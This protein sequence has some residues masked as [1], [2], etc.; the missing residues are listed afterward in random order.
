MENLK[1]RAA[2]KS[3]IGRRPENEDACLALTADDIDGIEGLLIVA[4]GMGG[5]ASGAVASGTAVK[6]VRDTFI[7]GISEQDL[8]KVLYRS[9]QAANDAVYHEASTKPEFQGMGTTCVAAAIRD[10]HASFVHMGDSRAYL[11]RDGRL[12]RLTEDHSFVAERVRAG[13]ISEEDARKS[14]FRNVITRAVG[15]EP[16][17]KPETSNLDLQSGDVLLLCTDGLSGPVTEN[18]I[19]DILCSSVT[20]EEACDQLINAALRNKGSDNITAVVAVY[21][22]R[23][24]QKQNRTYRTNGTNRTGKRWALAALV[25]LLVGIGVGFI[26]K[27]LYV[28]PEVKKVSAAKTIDLANV[29]Y[30][31][32]VSL[33][34]TPLQGRILSLDMSGNLHVADRQGCLMRVDSSGQVIYKFAPREFLKTPE[35][36]RSPMTATDHQGNLYISDPVG[37]RITKFGAD[38]LFLGNIAEDKL[39]APEALVINNKGSIYVIDAGRLK[40]IHVEQIQVNDGVR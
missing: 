2:W 18:E 1:I 30:G 40:A 24:V 29:T 39:T 26:P 8:S 7:S 34:Y 25:G 33:L 38:G 23:T 3:D 19:A 37:K 14:R 4:D 5:R 22:E 12:T 31:E 32:P 6:V 13:E 35:G 11:L 20:P 36:Q 9:L 10:G 21:G 27:T 17:A 16:T 28:K 15:L